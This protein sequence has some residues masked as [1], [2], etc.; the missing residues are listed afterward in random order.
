MSIV[1]RVIDFETSDLEPPG[2]KVIEVG[3]TDLTKDGDGPWLLGVTTSRLYG[4]DHISPVARAVHHISLDEVKDLPPFEPDRFE[5]EN[6]ECAAVVA[7]NFDYEAKFMVTPTPGVPS[8]PRIC[9]YKA[10]LRVWPNAPAH[11]NSV[12]RYWLEEDGALPV[13]DDAKAMP[14]HRAAPDSFVTAHIMRA[15]LKHATGKQ[16]AA[17]T[18][19]PRLLPTC[20]IGKPHRGKPWAQVDAGFLGWVLRQPDMDFDIKWNAQR[21]LDDRRTIA[22]SHRLAGNGKSLL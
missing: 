7:H 18:K 19:E 15:L 16:M 21:E 5:M 22:E 11:S 3:T 17:W 20:P 14:A 4:A 6:A 12:L 8:A 9:T 1:I 10:A 2:A 13:L